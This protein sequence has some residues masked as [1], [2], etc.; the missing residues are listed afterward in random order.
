MVPTD[1]LTQDQII[2]LTLVAALLLASGVRRILDPS[3]LL[4]AMI[5]GLVVSLM[6]H[7][8][9]WKRQVP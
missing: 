3:G 6:G 4:A 1:Y 2:S 5:V 8:T 7:W 9:Y